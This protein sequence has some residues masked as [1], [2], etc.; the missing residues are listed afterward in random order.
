MYQTLVDCCGIDP[1]NP[2]ISSFVIAPVGSPTN[3]HKALRAYALSF[4]GLV[5]LVVIAPFWFDVVA[6]L[7]DSVLM[8][9]SLLSLLK[10]ARF[11]RALA[12]LSRSSGTRPR[13][14]WP[15]SSR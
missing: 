5:D 12:F 10:L 4:L 1:S 9:A 8:M 2:R 14:F 11:V 7:P 13:A 6:R 15:A 3:P